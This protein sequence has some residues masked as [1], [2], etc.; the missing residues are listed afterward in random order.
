[1]PADPTFPYTRH[2]AP[3]RGSRM[4][5]VDEGAGDPIVFLHGNPTSSYLW[6]GVI[7]HAARVGRAIAFDMIGMGHSDKPDIPYRI[8]DQCE[9]FA[10]FVEELGLEGVHLVANDWGTA[11]AAQYV[12]EH[13][14]NVQSIAFVANIVIPWP[15]WQHFGGNSPTGVLWRAYRAPELGWEL[16]VN[17]HLFVEPALRHLIV[18]EPSQQVLD[19]YL[20]PYV[21]P[22]SRRPVWQ[23]A[24]D[25]PI[26]GEPKDFFETATNYCAALASSGLPALL[27]YYP[28]MSPAVEAYRS[29]LPDLTAVE[30][31]GAGHY[32]PEDQPERVG[33]E[34][35]G[36]IQRQRI[37]DPER[38]GGS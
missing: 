14:D 17:E 12:A 37:G 30:I 25:L 36:W 3:V 11:V 9:Y 31:D 13:R 7:P 19:H 23:L 27:L 29:F 1:M 32:M 16:C 33:E 21:S 24:N 15:T 38:I 6:R 20:E 35:A 8:Y 5:Y 22:E 26:A 18:E 2:L 10:D 34:V 4:A 28:Q